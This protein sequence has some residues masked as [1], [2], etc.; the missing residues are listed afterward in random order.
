MFRDVSLAEAGRGPAQGQGWRGSKGVDTPRPDA[1]GAIQVAGGSNLPPYM[2]SR[3]LN[4]EPPVAAL[5]TVI[6]VKLGFP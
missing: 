1:L 6:W 3:V 2:E 5:N 4:P